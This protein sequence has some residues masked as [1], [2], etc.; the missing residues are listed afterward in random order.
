MCHETEQKTDDDSQRTL[1]TTTVLMFAVTSH[2][3]ELCT[4]VHVIT[5][6]AADEAAV[7]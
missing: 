5:A 3:R 1:F 6:G 7:T 2:S 4:C